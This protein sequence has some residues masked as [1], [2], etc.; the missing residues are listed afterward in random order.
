MED[1]R[2]C[3]RAPVGKKDTATLFHPSSRFQRLWKLNLYSWLLAE[4]H[5]LSEKSA[6]AHKVYVDIVE[7]LANLQV[8]VLLGLSSLKYTH[9]QSIDKVLYFWK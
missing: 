5:D 8:C 6:N 3:A 9:F 1:A 4:L 7:N 2:N